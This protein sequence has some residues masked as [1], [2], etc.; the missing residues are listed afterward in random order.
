[1]PFQ[2]EEE[3]VVEVLQPPNALERLVRKIFV[4][5]FG[6]KLLALG[7]TLII[8]LA[9]TGE[10][11]PITIHTAVQL[12][13][14][15]PQGLE[16]SNDPPRTVEVLLT[17]SRHRLNGLRLLDLVATVNLSD[18]DPGDR[19]IRLSRERVSIDLPPGVR[20]DSFRPS[21]IPVRLEPVSQR[22]LPVEV[23]LD[24]KPADGFEVYGIQASPSAVRVSGPISHLDELNRAPTETVSVEGKSQSF[25]VTRLSIAITNQKLEPLDPV[26]DLT[27][28]IGE[29]RI[30]K[31]FDNVPVRSSN[32]D[33]AKRY[34][35]VTLLGPVQLVNQLKTEE[36]PV[37][38]ETSPG[39]Q[40]VP[41]VELPSPFKEQ[42]R[43]VSISPGVF[44]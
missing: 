13:F 1:M 44:R 15:R 42:I 21:T 29:K 40:K 41:R 25:T 2:D 23:R 11:K 4:E 30:E 26:I 36:I 19:V 16:V 3:T 34:V 18:S 37:L 38:L 17:G 24:G 39:G 14:V 10:N 27:V 32:Q 22:E 6:L 28:N 7:I 20:I 8:W 9:V 12:N 5:D 35:R 43:V 31:T 33:T